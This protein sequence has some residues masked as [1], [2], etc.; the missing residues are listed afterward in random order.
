MADGSSEGGLHYPE[1]VGAMVIGGAAYSLYQGFGVL[2]AAGLALAML[3]VGL[4]MVGALELG[5]RLRGGLN[6]V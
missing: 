6:G 5:K 1:M 2:H 3:A 4:L